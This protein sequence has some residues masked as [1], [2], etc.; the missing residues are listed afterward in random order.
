VAAA[1][2]AIHQPDTILHYTRRTTLGGPGAPTQTFDEEVWQAGDGSRQRVLSRVPSLGLHEE[3]VDE[4]RSLTYVESTNELIVYDEKAPKPAAPGAVHADPIGDPRTLLERARRGDTSVTDL[5]DAEVRGI[6]VAQLRIGR[7][8]I[9]STRTSGG[10]S[11]TYR[12]AFVVSIAKDSNLPV[13]V[14]PTCPAEDRPAGESFPPGDTFTDYLGFE[15]L[16]ATA[17]NERRLAMSPHPGA[18]TIDGEDVDAAEERAD[19]HFDP[20]PPPPP[21]ARP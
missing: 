19:K 10:I 7:C 18:R 1:Y 15:V 13:R 12:P 6:D 11:T 5:G 8:K 16:P 21:E 20:S 17:A 14:A 4:D 2:A 9:T 3:V